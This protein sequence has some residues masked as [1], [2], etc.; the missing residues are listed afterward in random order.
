VLVALEGLGG[1]EVGRTLGIP[2]ATVWTRLHHARLE[3]RE[4]LCREDR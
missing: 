2:V 1:E 3:L 4:A